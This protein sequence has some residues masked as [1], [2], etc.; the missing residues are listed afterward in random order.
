MSPGIAGSVI[1]AGRSVCVRNVVGACRVREGPSVR[2]SWRMVAVLLCGDRRYMTDSC[3][4]L[5][6]GY[7]AASEERR[8][9][10]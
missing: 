1:S 3:W 9:R 6:V 7:W 2:R 10:S 5:M 8:C 4:P